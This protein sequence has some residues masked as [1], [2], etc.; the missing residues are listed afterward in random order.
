[1]PVTAGEHPSA[2]AKHDKPAR[3][4]F[5]A[6]LVDRS[7]DLDVG[8]PIDDLLDAFPFPPEKLNRVSCNVGR[9]RI[10]PRCR[11]S[12]NTP[13]AIWYLISPIVVVL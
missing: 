13:A 3:I 11:R 2:V 8:V 1:V 9:H 10:S 6:S 4:P 7:G 5:D 12:G